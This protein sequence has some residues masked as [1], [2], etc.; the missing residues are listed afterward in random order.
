V[1]GIDDVPIDSYQL[2]FFGE[3]KR[4]KLE[5]IGFSRKV[6]ESAGKKAF[7][8]ISEILSVYQHNHPFIHGK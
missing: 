3:R 1:Q 8:T 4:K 5:P 7:Q 6:A 2:M